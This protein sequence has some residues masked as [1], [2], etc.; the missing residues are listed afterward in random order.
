MHLIHSGALCLVKKHDPVTA[1]KHQNLLLKINNVYFFLSYFSTLLKK[2]H[3]SHLKC[4]QSG[5]SQ[6]SR[7]RPCLL[8]LRLVFFSPL[9]FLLG[10]E[11][12]RGGSS[13]PPELVGGLVFRVTSR[14][15]CAF[16]AG[17]RESRS[18]SERSPHA[19]LY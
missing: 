8:S 18:L 12:A 6:V 3:D 9:L 1:D 15:T 14:L 5:V 19:N 16:C 13:S 7:Q 2:Q 4:C 11:V 17:D 10:T